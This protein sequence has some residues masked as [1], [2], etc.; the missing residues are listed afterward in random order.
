M[1]SD[2]IQQQSAKNAADDDRLN[3]LWCQI[4]IR[5]FIAET[6]YREY[7]LPI[8]FLFDVRS[9]QQALSNIWPRIKKQAVVEPNEI[10]NR[11]E[12]S[13]TSYF[14]RIDFYISSLL[15]F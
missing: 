8:F 11:V 4:Q 3:P 10:Q 1:R 14:S 7:D 12:F 15:P 5:L 13:S 6:N 9:L 2:S